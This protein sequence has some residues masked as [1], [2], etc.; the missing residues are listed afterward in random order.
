MDFLSSYYGLA[1]SNASPQKLLKFQYNSHMQRKG[2]AHKIRVANLREWKS[3]GWDERNEE[4]TGNEPI[5]PFR[6]SERFWVHKKEE[7]G[8]GCWSEFVGGATGS[9]LHFQQNRKDGNLWVMLVKSDQWLGYCIV[10]GMEAGNLVSILRSTKYFGAR[11]M[12]STNSPAR[13]HLWLRSYFPDGRVIV[14]LTATTNYVLHWTSVLPSPLGFWTKVLLPVMHFGVENWLFLLCHA[15]ESE[16]DCSMSAS[17]R[18]KDC[19]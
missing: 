13:L 10:Y 8:E 3:Q 16:T 2:D 14:A 5:P 1:H 6:P 17:T 9:R 4:V 15:N 19:E 7:L 12:T 11:H 18:G